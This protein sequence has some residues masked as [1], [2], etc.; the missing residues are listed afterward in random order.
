MTLILSPSG[1]AAWIPELPLPITDNKIDSDTFHEDAQE[2][3]YQAQ[4]SR[5]EYLETLKLTKDLILSAK[6]TNKGLGGP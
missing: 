1:D 4:Y 6:S 5:D 3:V 2:S